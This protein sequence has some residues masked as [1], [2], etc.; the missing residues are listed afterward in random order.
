MELSLLNETVREEMMALIND[1]GL[2]FVQ[3]SEDE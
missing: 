3:L 2:T 1:L